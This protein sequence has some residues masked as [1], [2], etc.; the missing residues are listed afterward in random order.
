MTAWLQSV[1]QT[2]AQSAGIDLPADLTLMGLM[3]DVI[4]DIRLTLTDEARDG[5]PSCSAIGGFLDERIPGPPGGLP[6][7]VP[8]QADTHPVSVLTRRL[9]GGELFTNLAAETAGEPVSARVVRDGRTMM[10]AAE[11][12]QL[13]AALDGSRVAIRRRGELRT[14]RTDRL[15]ARITSM[16]IPGRVWDGDA[17]RELEVADTPLGTVL[18]R[19]GGWREPLWTWPF[20]S[21]DTVIN[22][23]GRLWLPTRDGHRIPV[24]LA[25]EQ[26]CRL[27]WWAAA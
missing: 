14:A 7:C 8:D 26:V 16:I 21:Q 24:G 15:C 17:L 22:S 11:R 10:T 6:S 2:S 12:E 9:A 23:C 19:L 27:D 1:M 13:M 18:E 3:F 20:C 25:T 5:C 4:A